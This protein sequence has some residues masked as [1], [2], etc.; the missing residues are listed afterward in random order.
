MATVDG[1]MDL[2]DATRFIGSWCWRQARAFEVVGDWVRSETDP[3]VKIQFFS[4]SRRKGGHAQLLAALLPAIAGSDPAAFAQPTPGD[5]ELIGLLEG[6]RTG[7]TQ[8]RL[9]ALYEDLAP[10]EIGEIRQ[11]LGR[12]SPVASMPAIRAAAA[13]LADEEQDLRTGLALLARV[14]H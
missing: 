6:A 3:E 12:C 5:A 11:F 10:R 1:T 9:V 13:V 8:A 14:R 4:H 7:D 2:L